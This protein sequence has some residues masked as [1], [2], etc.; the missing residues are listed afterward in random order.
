MQ[1]CARAQSAMMGPSRCTA[2]QQP[3]PAL[4]WWLSGVLSAHCTS[5]TPERLPAKKRSADIEATPHP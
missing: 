2:W 4:S 3:R 5:G 1:R